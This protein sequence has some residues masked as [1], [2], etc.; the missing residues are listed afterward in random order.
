MSSF[1]ESWNPIPRPSEHRTTE[2]VVKSGK[3]H[4]HEVAVEREALVAE[5]PVQGKIQA[6]GLAVS[7]VGSWWGCGRNTSLKGGLHGYQAY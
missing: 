1:P 2:Q 3:R 6:K 5:F 4:R 7:G